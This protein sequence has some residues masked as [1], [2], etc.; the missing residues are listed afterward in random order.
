M[1]N[2]EIRRF[3]FRI[4]NDTFSEIENIA[5]VNRR[6]VNSEIIIA[7]ETYIKAYQDVEEQP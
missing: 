4:P 6:S 7:I 1:S 3:T 5:K 2:Q